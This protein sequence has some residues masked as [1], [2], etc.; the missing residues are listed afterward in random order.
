MEPLLGSLMLFPFDWAPRGWA[1]CDGSLLSISQYTA[2]FSLIGT[3]YGG[4]GRT[5]FALPDLRGRAPIHDGSGPGLTP[6]TIGEQGG[7]ETATLTANN[8]P[9]HSHGVQ[10][11]AAAASKS[12]AGQVPAYTDQG[13]SYGA[14]DGTVMN[15]GMVQPN[16]SAV[17]PISTSA[18]YLAMNYCIAL[19]GVFPSRS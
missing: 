17:A 10:A 9:P 7:A 19:E 5:T 3:T 14:P 8:L 4:D 11:S 12:P 2:L 1:R 18:P 15:A 16:Q 6:K 13:S